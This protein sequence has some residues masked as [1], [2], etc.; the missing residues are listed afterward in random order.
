MLYQ[1]LSSIKRNENFIENI[2]LHL[3]KQHGMAKKKKKKKKKKKGV[4]IVPAFS[5][6]SLPG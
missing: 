3:S 2:C 6:L 1:Q 5:S 4:S